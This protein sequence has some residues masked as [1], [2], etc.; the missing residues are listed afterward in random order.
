MTTKI[1]TDIVLEAYIKTRNEIKELEDKIS[2]L[3]AFQAKKEE[4]F[5]AKLD[6]DNATSFKTKHGT[7][8][9][10]IKESVTVA[11]QEVFFNWVKEND[12]WGFIEKRACKAEVLSA[13]GDREESGR[14]EPP[15][16]GLNYTAIKSVG[17]R[18]G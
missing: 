5:L 12:A 2:E 10:V 3:K 6:E 1:T 14:P 16:P 18:K 8:Y 17:V 15:P 11:D 9:T 7:V 4:W 13:M